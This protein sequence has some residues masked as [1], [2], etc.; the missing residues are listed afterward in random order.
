MPVFPTT[1]SERPSALLAN[2][3]GYTTSSTS[4]F[5]MWDQVPAEDQIGAILYYIISYR[6]LPSGSVQTK[7]VTAPEN[8]TTL[9][10]LNKYTNYSI[11]VFVFT[12]KGAGNVNEPI[13]IVTDEDRPNSPPAYV[14]GKSTS[15]TSIFVQWEQVP[16][17]YQNGVI[18][19]YTV[20]YYR[21]YYSR[22]PQTVVVAAPTTQVTLTGLNQS[23]HYSISLS[24]STSKGRGPSTNIYIATECPRKHIILNGTNGEIIYYSYYYYYNYYYRYNQKCSWK[25]VANK[26]EQ[27]ILVLKSMG[28]THCGF[29]CSCGHLEIQNGT[30]ADGT[31]TTRMC[32]DLLGNVT[33]YSRVGHGLGIQA[34]N[35]DL[36]WFN[37]RASYT[38]ISHKDTV[39]N[40]CSNYT[41]LNESN[42]A[43]TYAIRNL[44]NLSDSKLSG[45]YRFRGEA[46][47]QMAEVCPKMYSC[48]TNSSGWLSGTHPTVAEGTV[49]R[50]VCFS[51]SLSQFLQD[52]CYHSKNISVRNCGAFYV[53]RLDPPGYYSRYCSNG[54]PRAP[55]CSNYQLL[56]DCTRAVTY[57]RVLVNCKDTT[58]LLGW[59][60]FGGEA[61]SQMADTCVKRRHCG[62]WYPGWLSGGHPSVSDGAVLRKVCFTGYSR[63]CQYS[64][65]ISVRNCSGFYIYK[66]S[67]VVP[68]YYQCYYRYCSSNGLPTTSTT[69]LS[70]PPANVS[71]YNIS[72]TSIFVQW[73]QVPAAHQNGAVLYYTVTYRASPSG[74]RH[75]VFVDVP[76]NQ[77]TLTGLSGYTNYS[78]TVFA[79]TCKGAGNVSAPIFVFTNEGRPSAPPSNVRV[80][81]TN[82][83]SI[84]VQWDQVPAAHQNGLILYYTITYRVCYGG[85]SHTVV[86]VAPKTQTTLTGLKESTCYSISVSASTI[87]GDG[88]SSYINIATACARQ[89][90]ILNGTNGDII[91]DSYFYRYNQ[92]CSWKIMANK[93]E[94]IKLVLSRMYVHPWCGLSCSCGHLEIQ[95]A[96]YADGSTITRM[97]TGTFL[98]GNVTIYSHVGHD[99]GIQAVTL[100]SWLV[101]FRASYTVIRHKDTMSDECSDYTFLNGSNR[102]VTYADRSLCSLSDSKLSGWYRFSGGAGTQMAETC[103]KMYSCSTNSSGWLNDTHPTV[104]EGIVQRK[105]CFL[106]LVSQFFKDCC[107]HSKNISVRNCG[108]F[109]VYRLDPPDYYSRYCGNGL[110]QAP[111]CSNYKFLNE[112]IRAVTYNHRVF[113]DC[114]DA[115]KQL[116]WYR[117]GGETGTQMAD[118]CVKQYHC[119]TRYPGWLSG[120]H[121]SV[122]DGAVLR[123]VCFTEYTDCCYFSGFISVRNCS[124]FYVYK[125]SPALWYYYY[126]H[127]YYYDYFY[128]YYYYYRYEC[129]FRYCSSNGFELQTTSTT[130]PS[131]SSPRFSNTVSSSRGPQTNLS[132]T[133]TTAKTEPTTCKSSLT[134]VFDVSSLFMVLSKPACA[135]IRNNKEIANDWHLS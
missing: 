124:G 105:V 11:T 87:K 42:R 43:M 92:I 110:P 116:G 65:F 40:E 31:N 89:Q 115:T 17:P 18:L 22:F 81:S 1:G 86:V 85:F 54:L 100:P 53:Y 133:A 134:L 32:S 55:E 27:V 126:H 33:I 21:E 30:Y 23:T 131:A 36:W 91:S 93:R 29:S 51:Q 71:G 45:W 47:T 44:G 94:Q 104:A 58:K 122:S 28:F 12:I 120:G 135:W 130:A 108:A 50:K 14:S 118:T 90:K 66:L 129:S 46:G 2:V 101:S 56:N 96:T 35:P 3:S 37:F 103:P 125:L 26:G 74:S 84:S 112:S 64:T 107:Y 123:K 10:G 48:S 72:S 6:A 127:H 106:Q 24:A 76:P 68:F 80:N 59:Y 99:L 57:N 63:C 69:G 70:A 121:P 7:N 60:R 75:V 102:A 97:C 88:S 9:T 95:N 109:Y 38:V 13:F 83:T 77:I 67:P 62:A 25:I 15:S 5:V 114:D 52:C 119:G 78:I 41:F 111:E 16:A 8:Q 79:F 113:H 117:F 128:Y 39:S 49:Q 20:T 34:V 82:T 98:L 19:N 61:G 73:D 132:T 4:I